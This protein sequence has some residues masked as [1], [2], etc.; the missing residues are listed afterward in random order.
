MNN[1]NNMK[2][3]KNII[4]NNNNNNKNINKKKKKEKHSQYLKPRYSGGLQPGAIT[5]NQ[6]APTSSTPR[7]RCAG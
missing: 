5:S 2:K 7:K 1:N 6:I 4:N 3:K